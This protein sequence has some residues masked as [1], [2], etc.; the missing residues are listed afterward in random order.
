MMIPQVVDEYFE[1]CETEFSRVISIIRQLGL[2][3]PDPIV[4]SYADGNH[5]A[6]EDDLNQWKQCPGTK[7]NRYFVVPIGRTIGNLLEEIVMYRH[8]SQDSCIVYHA[9]MLLR[10]RD[11]KVV[12]KGS[13]FTVAPFVLDS[14]VRNTNKRI[15]YSSNGETTLNNRKIIQVVEMIKEITRLQKLESQISQLTNLYP[16]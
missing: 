10:D 5:G 3:L 12:G 14:D 4:H 2:H 6:Y 15:D 13:D 16:N 11:S 8:G 1:K 7:Y 9:E